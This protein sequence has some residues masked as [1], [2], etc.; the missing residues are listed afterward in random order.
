MRL[1]VGIIAL[2]EEALDTTAEKRAQFEWLCNKPSREHFGDYYDMLMEL[3]GEFG[4]DWNGTS[5]KTDG[6]LTPDAYFPKPYNFI[7]EFDE[8]QHFTRYREQTFNFYP[9]DIPLAYVPE[10]YLKF[11]QQYHIEALAKGPDRFRRVTADF[12]YV[13]GRAA[14]RAFFDTFRDWLPPKH[15]LNPTVRLAEFEVKPIL[16]GEL[17]GDAAKYYIK[18]LISERL[19]SSW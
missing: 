15:G 5:A 10:K 2:V 14:Q 16:D 11:C 8:L 13:N 1:E 12:P 3:Y 4:G 19:V 7:F 9:E 17:T 6:Y 18:Q